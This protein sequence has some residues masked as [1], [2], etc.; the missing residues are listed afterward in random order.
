MSPVH[1]WGSLALAPG[2]TSPFT[3]GAKV[4]PDR[5]VLSFLL[6]FFLPSPL[7]TEASLAGPL[8]APGTLSWIEVS[9]QITIVVK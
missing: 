6:F 9:C 2:R 3:H 4:M 7:P 5:E 8:P 1:V